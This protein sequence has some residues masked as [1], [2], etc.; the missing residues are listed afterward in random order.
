VPPVPAAGT[1]GTYPLT[2][3]AANIVLPNATQSFTLT[4]NQAAAITSAGITT[5]TAGKFGTFTVTTT[6]FP[7]S[8]LSETGALPPGVTFV[9]D[10]NGTATLAGTPAAGIVGA[11][12]VAFTATNG[13]DSTQSF[14]LIL[15]AAEPTVTGLSP[16]TGHSAGDTL[17]TIHGTDFT[18]ATVVDFGTNA[19]TGV[20]VVNATTITAVSPAG[21][22]VV[23]VTVTTLGG[24]SASSPAD[25][26]TYVHVVAPPTGMSL[27]RFGF[28]N[29]PTSLVMT[30][31]SA[32]DATAAQ[33]VNNYQIVGLGA[34]GRI[35]KRIRVRAAVYDPA[36]LT[37]TV[38]PAQ[39]LS[40]HKL[41]RLTVNGMTPGGLT[42]AT[43]VPLAGQGGVSGTNYVEV[44]S[45]KILAGPA[46]ATR[47]V[48][49]PA[50]VA[51]DPLI[52]KGPSA[53]AV[54]HLLASG[55]LSARRLAARRHSEH[56]HPLR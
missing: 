51:R 22:G 43:G 39:R 13:V 18:G 41:Y 21:T 44:I 6:G 28:R 52:E 26:F 24:T 36:T 25:Q 38:D 50:T 49:R 11:Y 34:R 19:A 27:V 53:A 35:G 46:P 56:H 17:V 54:D 30:F 48:V 37:V 45:G 3:T 4:V 14:T 10:G 42:G 9:D 47:G 29:Q 1:G 23:N 20:T 8:A 16:I 31:S 32:L 40:L 12:G 15:A 55:K 2:I 5:F 7:T 33:N